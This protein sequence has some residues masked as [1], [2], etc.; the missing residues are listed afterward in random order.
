MAAPAAVPTPDTTGA[1]VRRRELIASK[2]DA[3]LFALLPRYNGASYARHQLRRFILAELAGR[4]L[5]TSA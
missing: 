3:E 5:A 4:G 1:A 2:S